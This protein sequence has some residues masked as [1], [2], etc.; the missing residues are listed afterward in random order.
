MLKKSLVWAAPVIISIAAVLLLFAENYSDVTE[1]PTEGWSRGIKLGLTS[2]VTKPHLKSLKEGQLDVSYLTEEGVKK[3]TFNQDFEL[4]SEETI[5]IPVDKFT[6]FS[7]SGQHLIY[8]DYQSIFI[9]ES[10]EK[11]S[12][13]SDFFP[14]K[15][16]TLYSKEEELF[17]LDTDTLESVAIMDLEDKNTEI[18]VTETEQA[19]YIMTRTI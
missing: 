12:D 14:L 11:L 18:A 3:D 1:P 10:G 2:T 16:Q 17:K 7:W 13:I 19:A 9:G 4:V 5:S 8:S 6:E 15:D